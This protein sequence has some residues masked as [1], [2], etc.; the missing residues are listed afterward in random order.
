MKG[1]SCGAAASGCRILVLF[2]AP[3]WVAREAADRDISLTVGDETILA[4]T[5]EAWA[6]RRVRG[7][8]R[9]AGRPPC[10]SRSRWRRAW[11]GAASVVGALPAAS[12]RSGR[13][14]AWT[15]PG[16]G[17]TSAARDDPRRTAAQLAAFGTRK[18]CSAAAV[19][20]RSD[21]VEDAPSR[22]ERRH[23]R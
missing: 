11:A 16:S 12:R 20:S 7:R 23:P 2:P 21:R 14:R 3:P 1:W 10:N 4:R 19:G 15:S 18:R 8:S 17:R 22:R 6:R 9:S 13:R 5:L